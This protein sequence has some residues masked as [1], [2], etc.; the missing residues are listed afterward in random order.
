MREPATTATPKHLDSGH[1][2]LAAGDWPAA[3]RAFEEALAAEQ[4]AEAFEGLSWA[5]W[6]LDERD[7]VFLARER[8]YRL[9]QRSGDRIGAA[10]MAAWLA[11][12]QLDF[13]GAIAAAR[14]W[15]KRGERAL[16]G[17]EGESVAHGWV[18]FHR[19]YIAHICGE[20][21]L[22]EEKGREASGIGRR[23]GISDLEML[24]LALEGATSVARAEVALG[25]ACLDEA[26][27]AALSE[28]VT[29][30]IS[31]AWTCCFLVSACTSVLD[32][33]RA[34]EWC[35]RIAE[36]AD[37]Y[38]SRYMLGFCR[39]GY[40]EVHLWRGRWAEAEV[41]L[42]EA[43]VSF[44]RSRPAFVTAPLRTLAELRRRQ[45][46]TDECRRLLDRADGSDALLSRARLALDEGNPGTAVRLAERFLRQDP[47]ERQM[48][49]A[50]ALALLVVAY[51]ERGLLE[52]AERA[53]GLLRE[54]A[55]RVG[56]VGFEAWALYTEGV[57]AGARG[58]HREASQRLEDALDHFERCAAPFEAGQVQVA[59]ARSLAS[60]GN[61]KEARAELESAIRKFEALGAAGEAGRAEQLR[62]ALSADGRAEVTAREREVLSELAR[63]LTNREIAGALVIS[64]H[65]VHRHV[66]NILR[67][68]DLPTRTAAATWAMAA[69]LIDRPS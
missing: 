63:G 56:T 36:F 13:N 41:V 54:T 14:G 8:A 69:G 45:G 48:D 23:L 17:I 3:R 9:Y 57:L 46:R 29:V 19:G 11:A 43:I 24:G 31:S 10:L 27:A 20:T 52:E 50:P 30:P 53:G 21:E 35:D 37:R 25:M 61:G 59:L 16:E 68:L 32:H 33:N 7:L 39:S 62:G 5:A 55:D 22:A 58:D 51:C 44:E 60:L 28:D 2:L 42:D 67:K 15:L 40:G 4:S 12:D 47:P 6:W 64:E 18:A 66:T 34:N 49:H 1:S 65:T 38:G 26:T